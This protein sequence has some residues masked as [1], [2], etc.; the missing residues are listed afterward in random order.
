ME[1]KYKLKKGSIFVEAAIFLPIVII[2]FLTFSYLIKIIY[3]Q[4]SVFSVLENE[5]RKISQEAYLYDSNHFK[6]TLLHEAL[7]IG[8]Q[9]KYIFESRLIEKLD[10]LNVQGVKDFEIENF[11]FMFRNYQIDD[12]I[13]ISLTYKIENRLSK[14]FFDKFKIKQELLIRAWTGKSCKSNNFLF[15]EMEKNRKALLV[16]IFPRAGEKYHSENCSFIKSYP[17]ERILISSIRNSYR[18]CEVC[19]ANLASTGDIVYVFK[20]GKDYHLG[21]CVFVDKYIISIDKNEAEKRGFSACQKCK[22]GQ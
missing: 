20:Y 21:D 2:L 4:E 10:N 13:E 11:K 17:T 5:G 1:R 8:P 22:G 18:A 15:S 14:V 7:K 9:N 12:L 6:N 16:Y 3:I 19:Q